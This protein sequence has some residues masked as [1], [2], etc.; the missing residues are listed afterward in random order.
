MCGCVCLCVYIVVSKGP[1]SSTP[2]SSSSTTPGAAGA[3]ASPSPA[4]QAPPSL[5]LPLAQG[6][7]HPSPL[8]PL[9]SYSFPLLFPSSIFIHSVTMFLTLAAMQFRVLVLIPKGN[10]WKR[11]THFSISVLLFSNALVF[12]TN[13]KEN[14]QPQSN[15]VDLLK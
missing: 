11:I 15:N 9:F 5:A 4:S 2:S 8:H 7:R 6:E 10:F 3:G 13:S 14:L 12:N 1:V